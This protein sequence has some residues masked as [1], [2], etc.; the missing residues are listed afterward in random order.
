MSSFTPYD[1]VAHQSDTSDKNDLEPPADG[2]HKGCTLVDAAAFTAKSGQDWVKLEWQTTTGHKWTV[3]QGFKSD[4]QTAVTWSEVSK[5][6]INPTEIASLEQ[7]DEQLKT[8]VG[9]YFD[10]SVKTSPD[11]RFRNTYIEGRSTE[12]VID[13]SAPQQG[14]PNEDGQPIPF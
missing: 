3:L 10:L 1:P 13:P 5:L 14:D 11:G 8:H 6:G 2:P 9:G 4:A 7:L 12:R